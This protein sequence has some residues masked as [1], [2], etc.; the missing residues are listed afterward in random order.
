M[1]RTYEAL[2]HGRTKR[3]VPADEAE[4]PPTVFVPVFSSPS[5]DAEVASSTHDSDFAIN[6]STAETPVPDDL[7]KDNDN[8]PYIEVGGPRGSKPIYGPLVADV[9]TPVP[10]TKL[11][12]E[13]NPET[14]RQGMPVQREDSKV[15]NASPSEP[16]AL[17]VAF[18]PLP[19][20]RPVDTH[21]VTADLIAF[22]RPNHAQ[23]AQYR[24]VLAGLAA[25]HP[26]V[27]HHLLVFTTV[28]NVQEA[29]TILL[30]TAVTR[31]QEDR[32]RV[33]V[34]EANHS[35][36]LIAAQVGVADRPGL[37]ELLNRSIPMS[38]ALHATAQSNLFVLPPGDSDMPVSHE[39]EAR[40]P[41]L[42]EQ[43]RQRFDWL[44]VNGPEWGSGG[45]ADWVGLGDAAYLV[46]RRDNWDSPEVEAAHQAILAAGGK[47]RGYVTL[48][49]A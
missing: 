22:H 11:H 43:L 14:A 20:P 23:T 34:I 8:V 28:G 2:S 15:R 31:A 39:S 1:G 41:T 45:S 27:G 16:K 18:F 17:S 12:L 32:K 3:A 26:G 19:E 47:L 13:P 36:P 40:L 6:Q 38:A 49:A 5:E 7:S 4:I 29:A 37:R 9:P 30:N 42:I 24:G 10:Q 21:Q 25:Q 44:L 46:V 33:L 48:Q 35:N